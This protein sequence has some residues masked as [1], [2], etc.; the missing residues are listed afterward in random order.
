MLKLLIT[1]SK[2]EWPL[3]PEELLEGVEDL[4]KA[5]LDVEWRRLPGGDG[6]TESGKV[7]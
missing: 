1:L 2:V 3:V 6:R 4:E 5:F 7:G